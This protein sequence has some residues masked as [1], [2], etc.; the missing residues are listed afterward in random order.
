MKAMKSMRLAGAALMLA[1]SFGLSSA[2]AQTAAPSLKAPPKQIPAME[3][4]ALD[5]VK[6]MSTKL[7]SAKTL[8]FQV[9]VQ[10]EAPSIDNIAVIYTSNSEFTLQRPNKLTAV[11]TGQGN[12]SELI[13]DGQSVAVITPDSNLVAF[14]KAPGNI[15][16]MAQ[17]IFEKAGMYFPGGMILLSDPY[18]NITSDLRA[19]FIVEKL[20]LVGGVETDV[21]VLA[22][23]GVEGQ[24]WIGSQD[25]LPYMMTM[26][27]T[28]EPN[29]PRVTLEFRD[30][31]INHAVDAKRF[32]LDNV[33]DAIKV[34]FARIDA[35][36]K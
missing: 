35:P 22:G 10:S 33:K 17:F 20:K 23:S 30:W 12:P 9:R 13:Y 16:A 21:V 24:F 15:D 8:Q 6:A 19:A 36:L 14:S 1:T 3:Q 31:K 28:K 7:A 11:R 2:L 25:K 27:Y 26:I 34:D 5:I 4:G 18:A 29:R 32:S